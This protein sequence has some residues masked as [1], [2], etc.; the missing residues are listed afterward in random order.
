MQ[1]TL[2][3]TALPL[4]LALTSLASSLVLLRVRQATLDLPN[5]LCGFSLDSANDHTVDAQCDTG[6]AIVSSKVLLED[7]LANI[8][9][10]LSVSL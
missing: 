1:L 4:F 7:C 9:G 6:F 3:P 5:S 8:N 2:T 10:E